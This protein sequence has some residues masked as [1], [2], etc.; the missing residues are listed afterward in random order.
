MNKGLIFDLDGVIVD[1]AKYHFLAWQDL[2]KELDIE[3]TIED[4][5]RLKGVSR[6]RSFQIILEIGEVEMPETEQEIYCTK[7]NQKYVEYIQTLTKDDCLPGAY[8]FIADAREKGYKIALGSAS[9]NA[10][11]ILNKLELTEL[12]DTIADGTT[13][14][15]AK[16]DPEV[17]IQG[18]RGMALDY[19]DCI[20]FEDSFAGIDAAHAAGMIAVGIGDPE[21]L[22]KADVCYPGFEGLTI[23]SLMA[24]I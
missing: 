18:A 24:A 11:F 8:E 5:E 10:R 22:P 19:K 4:N 12:F 1:T 23:E 6:V 7:K 20:V 3:F 17:F 14:T 13:V 16:P 15:K 9:K 21:Q 2:A